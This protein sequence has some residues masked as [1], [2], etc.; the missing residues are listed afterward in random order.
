MEGTA[1][2]IDRDMF[3]KMVLYLNV[4]HLMI[5]EPSEGFNLL[6]KKLEEYDIDSEA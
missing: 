2:C 3:D 1:V 6:M 5:E 4:Y